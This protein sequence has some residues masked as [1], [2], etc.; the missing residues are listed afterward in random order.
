MKTFQIAG[1]EIPNRYVLAP[2]AGFTDYSMRK[3]S[4]EK[5]AGL[6]YTEMESCEALVF[7]SKITIKDLEDT[8]LDKKNFPDQK[9][10]LQ[11]FGGKKDIILKSIPIVEQY[12]QY[13]FLDFNCGC[14][15]PKVIR[16][17]AGS[18]WLNRQDELVDLMKE[19]VKV[20]SKPVIIKI[21]IGF[22]T[23][24][25]VVTLCKRLEDVGVSAIAVHGRTRKEM[26]SSP[27][28]Y[29]VIHEIKKNTHIPIIA[30]GEIRPDNL[31]AVEEET[32]ADAFM[33][34]QGAIGNPRIFSSLIAVEEGKEIKPVSLQDQ[35]IDLKEHLSEIFSIKGEH[36]AAS[37][38]RAI[39]IR[40]FKGFS[41]IK[42]YKTRLVQCNTQN[43]Y[44]NILDE[45]MNEHIS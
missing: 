30:N 7:G 2:L 6:C 28:H 40:Y 9:L 37:I 41:D 27:V 24:T 19:L 20:S 36:T 21:R 4:Y 17:Q 3:M 34:G 12:A 42:K 18:Y 44:L 22:S 31:L 10:V 23:I 32:G 43:E 5:G 13:D 38:M 39:S 29:D 15:V 25:D 33:I 1:I 8:K 35:I 26:F 45:M 16:Q 14:P 11:I